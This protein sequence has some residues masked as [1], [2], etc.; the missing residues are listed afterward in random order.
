M[1]AKVLKGV[2]SVTAMSLLLAACGS[3]SGTKESDGAAANDRDS[4]EVFELGSEPLEITM[5][6][7]Y[8]WYT[9]DRWGDDPATAAIKELTKVDIRAIDGGGN[10]AQR[11]STMIAGDD[12][13]DFIWLDRGSDVERLREAGA[14][15]PFDDYLD[16]YPNLKEWAG[17]DILNM[18]RSEDG[19]LYQ[20][21]NWYS[22]EPFGNAGYVVNKEIHDA[23]GAPELKTTDDLYEYLKEVQT[24]FP[25]VIPFETDVSGQ[26]INVLYSA[27]AEGRS[28]ADIRIRA[29]PEG[30]VLTSIFANENYVESIEYASRLYRE[31]LMT[32]DTLTQDA[33]MVAEKVT[34]GR[35]AVY[36]AASP[37][38]HARDAHYILQE[39]NPDAGYFYIEPI[40]KP[41]LD[42]DNI[43]PGSYEMLGWNVSV[44]TRNAEDPEKVFAFLDWLTGPLGQSILMFGPEGQYW[45]G[46]DEE[47]YTKFTDAYAED[48]AGVSEIE[49]ATSSFQW[50]GNSAFL[51]NTKTKFEL[52]LP[53][54][55]M[56]WATKWQHAITWDTQ[57][58][59]TEFAA[60][61]PMPDSPE[62]IIQ[63]RINDIF[64]EANASAIFADSD[65]EVRAIF[66]EAEAQAQAAGY[67]ELL[68]YQTEKWQQNLQNLA[69]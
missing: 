63:Q 54:D 40:A 35:V 12:L 45:D 52:N 39:Q 4:S 64:E 67:Q 69:R 22:S 13:P 53:E 46:F 5:F 10:A 55:Q 41:G 47:G 65:E 9:M 3:E 51:D 1:K 29:V 28:P 24:E 58:D 42:P 44:I 37:S 68:D 61:N 34:S 38:N 8:D 19:K 36:A 57:K 7:N 66:A 33:D 26:G 25:D 21:P 32:Q 15:V 17:E 30:D 49:Q 56:N 6:G 31:R 50:N 16:K 20:F 59:D 11:L 18:L 60:I 27:F 14:L 23:L 43:F 2:L 48:S 62:G